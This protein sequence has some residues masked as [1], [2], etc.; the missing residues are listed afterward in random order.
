MWNFFFFDNIIMWYLNCVALSV[1]FGEY[2]SN[3]RI[4]TEVILCK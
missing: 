3:R 2:V 4:I 1:S